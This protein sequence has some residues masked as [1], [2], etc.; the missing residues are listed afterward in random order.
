MSGLVFME[1]PPGVAGTMAFASAENSDPGD[2]GADDRGSSEADPQARLTSGGCD[3]PNMAFFRVWHIPD[4]PAGVSNFVFDGPTFIPVDFKDYREQVDHLEVLLDGSPTDYAEYMS[5]YYNGAT[6]WGM[7]IYF[8]RLPSGNYQLQLR[9]TVRLSEEL[10][11]D[12]GVRILTGPVHPI[13]VDNQVTFTNWND[14]IWDNANFQFL[15]QTKNPVTDWTVDIYDAYG[16]WVNGGSGHTTNGL[17][18]WTW[19][20]LDFH[21]NPRD[22]LD[23]D[24]FFAPFI[25]FD[26]GSGSAGTSV[27]GP[28]PSSSPIQRQAPLTTISYPDKGRWIVAYQDSF[29]ETNTPDGNLFVAAMNGIVGGIS[30]RGVPVQ[31]LPLKFGTNY[32]Q[33]ERNGS[34]ATL[35]AWMLDRGS[36]N[37]YYFG[38]GWAD[39]IGG[40]VHVFSGG[41]AVGGMRLPNSK[42][43][44]TSRNIRDEI[45]FNKYGGA[46]PYRFVWL[47][48]CSTAKGSWPEAFGVNKG[49]NTL[50]FY[51][52]TT[53]N[54]QRKRPSA[55]AG[56]NRA[57]GSQ[58][59]GTVRAFM[60]FRSEWMFEW[61]Q[62]WGT[63]GVVAAF[64]DA[65]YKTGWV[66][67][68]KLWGALCVYG[69]TELRMNE[70]N[71]K[72]DWP[73]Q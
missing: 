55:F 4:F 64:E 26:A 60:L 43:F 67:F 8:D 53:T 59:W 72:S 9:S 33:T 34:W 66:D 71:N 1:A 7:G 46:R 51:T 23:Y 36:R 62:N 57:I 37:L 5:L 56:W 28:Q 21:G 44:I 41:T 17:I 65:R 10:S 63:K 68:G 39:G 32:T 30:L 42:A 15:A 47:D 50:D 11:D 22:D 6:N 20:L 19:D 29:F 45:T 13:V 48:G 24:P 49:T 14:L 3:C 70:F 25:T 18:E 52:S 16:H 31:S 69:Y 35:K 54:P 58:G 27:N 61:Q 12:T 38:H 40:D 73:P 2:V